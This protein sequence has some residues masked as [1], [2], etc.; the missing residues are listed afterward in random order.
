MQ[1]LEKRPIVD[2]DNSC[3]IDVVRRPKGG[4]LVR[5]AERSRGWNS[6]ED[7]F[8]TFKFLILNLELKPFI[9]RDK[10][11]AVFQHVQSHSRHRRDGT[12][13]RCRHQC[14][15][16]RKQ[17]ELHHSSRYQRHNLR[18]LPKARRQIII[19]QARPG[20]PRRCARYFRSC[21]RSR[22]GA[23]MGCLLGTDLHGQRCDV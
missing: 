1:Q 3:E 14:P 22:Q 6:L 21:E 16:Q 20:K 13:G 15:S 2:I 12:A 4:S 23:N 8:V 17:P 10:A 7:S 9:S 5:G 11:S 18:Q 19:D